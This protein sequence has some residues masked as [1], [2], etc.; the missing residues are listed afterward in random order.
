MKDLGHLVTLSVLEEYSRKKVCAGAH[1]VVQFHAVERQA[2]CSWSRAGP[3]SR[4]R[5]RLLTRAG[6]SAPGLPWPGPSGRAPRSQ[7][8]SAASCPAPCCWMG[9]APLTFG[10]Y[11][12]LETPLCCPRCFTWWEE[13]AKLWADMETAVAVH[14]LLSR[15]FTPQVLSFR[16]SCG[17]RSCANLHIFLSIDKP[18]MDSFIYLRK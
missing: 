8:L 17:V 13:R 10:P 11:Q 5:S 6:F 12:S 1:G 9:R 7:Q 2:G 14:L 16:D 15:H 4:Q 3:G 18:D